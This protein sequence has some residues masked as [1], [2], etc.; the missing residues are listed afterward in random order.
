MKRNFKFIVNILIYSDLKS[1]SQK[2]LEHRE[3]SVLK[4][5]KCI[6]NWHNIMNSIHPNVEKNNDAHNE[7][8]ICPFLGVVQVLRKSLQDFFES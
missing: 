3:R 2:N 1:N 8:S 6:Q 4:F 7:S 5:P